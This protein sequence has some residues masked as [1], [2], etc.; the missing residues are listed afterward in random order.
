M[1][2][3]VVGADRKAVRLHDPDRVE[4]RPESIELVDELDVTMRLEGTEIVMCLS[5]PVTRLKATA[6]QAM[7]LALLLCDAAGHVDGESIARL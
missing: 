1:G 6:D 3:N 7:E 2:M 5:R 4:F